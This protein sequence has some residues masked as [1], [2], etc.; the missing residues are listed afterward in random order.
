MPEKDVRRAVERLKLKE[1][2]LSASKA[3]DQ[4]LLV[5]T[6]GTKCQRLKIAKLD[7]A[8]RAGTKDSGRCT[9]VLT[10]GDSAFLWLF[11]RLADGFAPV[12][13]F[14]E[15]I[16]LARGFRQT[17]AASAGQHIFDAAVQADFVPL[18]NVHG[19]DLRARAQCRPD[20]LVFVKQRLPIAHFFPHRLM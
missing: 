8:P 18:R 12:V 1:I 6:N 14:G 2:A 3:K 20:D 16:S 4:R 13:V 9:L 19:F 5:A 10:E 11:W 15:L 17:I 7:D